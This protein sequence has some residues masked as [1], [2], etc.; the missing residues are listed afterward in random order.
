MYYWRINGVASNLVTTNRAPER[1]RPKK[2]P[3]RGAQ[4]WI[5][6]GDPV[7]MEPKHKGRER[8]ESIINLAAQ[9][10]DTRNGCEIASIKSRQ[11]VFFAKSYSL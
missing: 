6:T 9:N 1:R 7:D 2:A 10:G 4:G 8:R 11:N 5:R 3:K